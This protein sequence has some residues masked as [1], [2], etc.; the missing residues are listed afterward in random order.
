MWTE[1]SVD[2]AFYVSGFFDEST[3]IQLA[4]STR[5]TNLQFNK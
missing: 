2:V 1:E 5:N 3:L 4:E